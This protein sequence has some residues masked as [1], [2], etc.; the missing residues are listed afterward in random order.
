M[1]GSIHKRF[2]QS[3]GG[4]GGGGWSKYGFT[5]IYDEEEGGTSGEIL[6]YNPKNFIK[7]DE[8]KSPIRIRIYHCLAKVV[9]V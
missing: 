3:G 2:N 4:G 9:Y 1:L 8:V 5:K 7:T 6:K